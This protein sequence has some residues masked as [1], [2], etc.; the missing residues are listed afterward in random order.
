[1]ILG[2]AYRGC[3][4]VVVVVLV[5]Y[6]VVVK[7]VKGVSFFFACANGGK[8]L[9][10]GDSDSAEDCSVSVTPVRRRWSKRVVEWR[11]CR[12]AEQRALRKK[13]LSYEVL[14]EE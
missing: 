7:C 1:M 2:G 10:T 14:G 6:A 11:V 3:D 4:C 13:L 12:R 9:I 8:Q 5:L